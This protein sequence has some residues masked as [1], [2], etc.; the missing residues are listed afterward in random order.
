M[1]LHV[2]H[3]SRLLTL[4]AIVLAPAPALAQPDDMADADP[5]AGA[6]I[7]GVTVSGNVALV[8]DYRF[9]GVSASGGDLAVQGGID[10][11]DDSGFYAGAWA[12]SID[13][14]DALGEVELDVYGGWSG[15]VTEALV[16]DAG[17]LYYVYPT[18]DIGANVNYWEPYASIST[19]LGPAEATIGVAY[20]W[21]QA[22]LGGSDNL[23]VYTDLGAGL[24]GT[25]VTL[26]AHLGF[27][28][29][30]LAPAI[31]AGGIDDSGF[32]YSLGASVT[33]FGGLEV[34]VAYVGVDGPVID[35]LTDDTIT[36]SLGFSF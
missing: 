11:N 29:G 6:A 1:G 15:N 16:L 32:D 18:E 10:L 14:G 27:T 31:L 5:G 12:S 13:G 35:G 19:S 28:D 36:A 23:Y 26:S 4:S 25:P 20:A 17:L 34:A 33:L 21:E 30:A 9:R 7:E 22:S 8:S 24:P 3:F 2:R